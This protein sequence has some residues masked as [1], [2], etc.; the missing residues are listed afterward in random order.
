MFL[1]ILG[2]DLNADKVRNIMQK[3]G[4]YIIVSQEEYEVREYLN[5]N[6]RVISSENLEKAFKKIIR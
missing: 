6:E 1:V 4:I 5:S 2:T 3:E